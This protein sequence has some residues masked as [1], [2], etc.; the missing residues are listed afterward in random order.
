M[1]Q[2]AQCHGSDYK[3]GVSSPSCAKCHNAIPVHV[4]G[5]DNPS[6]ANFHGKYLGV[7]G[8]TLSSCSSCHGENFTGGILSPE[9][10]TCHPTIDIHK[11][12]ITNPESPNFHAK[13]I[14]D[15]NADLNNCAACHGEDFM[16]GMSAPSCNTCH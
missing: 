9:C 6:S 13:Y 1:P 15:N 8:L 4:D 12:G 3:G 16:G 14:K 2:C 10:A 5:I 7:N 11:T